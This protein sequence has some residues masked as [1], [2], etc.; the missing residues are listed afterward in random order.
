MSVTVYVTRDRR[1]KTGV[2]F[3]VC[4]G[5]PTRPDPTRPTSSYQGLRFAS[6]TYPSRPVSDAIAPHGRGRG[7]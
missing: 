1:D 3:G 6:K 2:T 4:R 7:C 5:C